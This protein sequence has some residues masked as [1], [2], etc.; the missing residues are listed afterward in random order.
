MCDILQR[1]RTHLFRVTAYPVSHSDGIWLVVVSVAG[2]L[3]SLVRAV[4]RPRPAAVHCCAVDRRVGASVTKHMVVG[5][6]MTF[7]LSIMCPTAPNT[8][9]SFTEVVY[10]V[11]G[12]SSDMLALSGRCLPRREHALPPAPDSGNNADSSLY[13]DKTCVRE[14]L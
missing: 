14:G 13:P 6:F 1:T 11:P 7:M 12:R 3:V 10:L 9:C 8:Y 2:E 5:W 4:M